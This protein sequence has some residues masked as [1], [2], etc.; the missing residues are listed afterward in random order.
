MR[1]L[2]CD[3]IDN[4]GIRRL[5]GAGFVVDVKP[6]IAHDELRK[7][8]PNYDVLVVR[9]R[10]KVSR[11]VLDAGTALK[12]VGRAGAGL[13]N[14]D[15][16]AAEKKGVKVLNTP[17]APAE[18]VAE[19]TIGLLL[20]LTRKIPSADRTMKKEEWVKK[21]LMGWELKGKTLGTIGLGNVGE[22]VA[23]MAKAFGM[24]IL[25][26]KRTPPDPALLRELRAEFVTLQDLL[27]RS[28]IITIHI[29]YTPQT[30]H[31]IGKKEL[32]MT[33]RG[34]F[35]I[36]TSRGAIVD[37]KALLEAL[38]SGRLRGA[39]LDVYES[40]PPKDWTLMKLPNV[41]CTPHIGAQTDE[42]QKTASTLLA[43]KIIAALS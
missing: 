28:D 3:P 17:E 9:S 42:A 23:R 37:E 1:I 26:T 18:A 8:V 32:Q 35:I 13:D 14:I 20:S 15:V 2:V 11:E 10:T 36:N 21:E 31:M 34:A 16:E 29:P 40:E 27:Q 22:K 43:E 30:H 39:G 4:E 6:A 19:L 7:I 5:E 38:Q 25:V 33:K 41:V 12:V 24:E